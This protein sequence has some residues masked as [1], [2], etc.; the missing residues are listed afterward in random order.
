M[1]YLTAQY[2]NVYSP[3]NL[4]V[5][6]I[7]INP[8]IRFLNMIE[9]FVLSEYGFKFKCQVGSHMKKSR[10]TGIMANMATDQNVH[11]HPISAHISRERL[12]SATPR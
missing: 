9:S 8:R 12:E 1:K 2:P 11:H 3:I 10:Q 4:I 5:E 7:K 6:P